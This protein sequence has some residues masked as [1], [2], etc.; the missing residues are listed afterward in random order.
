YH[1]KTAARHR[2]A[3]QFT[4]AAHTLLHDLKENV[5]TPYVMVEALGWFFSLPLFG[6]TFCP[7]WYHRATQW[8][9][10]LLVPPLATTLTIDKLTRDQAE[11]MV[12][13]EQRV[14]IR[15]I[16]RADFHLRGSA[17]TP[18]LIETIRLQ[19]LEP[20]DD[21]K[22][23]HVAKMLAIKPTEEEALYERLRRELKMTPRGISARLDRITQNG[24]S[25]A[26]QAYGVEAG[27]R[28]MGLTTGFA[29]LIV[30]C[31]HGSTSAN[32]PYESALDCGA[33][34]GNHGLP[35]ARAFA[36]MAN[37]PAVR[38][39]LQGRGI[40]IPIDTH[41]MAAH[42]DTTGD[43][44]RIV[45]L[46]DVPATHRKDLARLMADLDE[47]GAYAALD[48]GAM[49]DPAT[50]TD[51]AGL[52]QMK[53]KRRGADWAQVRPEW[54]LSRNSLFIVGSRELTRTVNLQGRAF[55]HSY[56]F[57]QDESGRLLETIMTAPLVVAQWINMEHYFSTVDNDIYGSGSKV[58]HNVVA[59][60]GVMSGVSSDLRI[61]L[62]AQTVL[63]GPRPY[64][65]PVRLLA[66]IE[67]PRERIRAIILKHPLLERLFDYG[68]V[69][70]VALDPK[71]ETF[72]E[73]KGMAGWVLL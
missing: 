73:Y 45:D 39:I 22:S 34:G 14:R 30:F 59:R 71:D 62:P 37:T 40:T 18:T 67:A 61:G 10:R 49:L 15:Q 70:L 65:E 57:R 43:E 17:V 72:Y 55:L 7:F 54:G 41:F 24:F 29:R 36:T 23:G 3:A 8:L 50:A 44:L 13:S 9:K 5:I 31:G 69:P 52:A 28:L 33:C 64:H 53:A 21:R 66:V 2:L 32:N 26:E 16:L 51:R 63:D 58:Y 56:E 47:A 19:A 1:E 60:V 38:E 48:R 6:K 11:E 42:H 46:E 27:L 25:I 4:K 68:W 20:T 35:N 12:A